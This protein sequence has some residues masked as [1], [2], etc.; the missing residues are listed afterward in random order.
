MKLLLSIVGLINN[1]IS[2]LNF[3]CCYY[4]VTSPYISRGDLSPGIF[5]NNYSANY[6]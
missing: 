3:I 6:L 2:V 5:V 1:L 4:Q